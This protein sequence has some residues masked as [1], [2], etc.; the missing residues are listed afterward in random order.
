MSK[1]RRLARLVARRWRE[2]ETKSRGTGK[3]IKKARIRIK[4][5]DWGEEE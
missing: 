2:E 5:D 4:K 1:R 3:R